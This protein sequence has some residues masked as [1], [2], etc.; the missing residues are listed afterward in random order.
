MDFVPA[1][2]CKD[3]CSFGDFDGTPTYEY[4]DP[5]EGEQRQWGTK[6]GF[7]GL[8]RAYRHTYKAIAIR[9]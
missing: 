5:R 3:G 8:K 2:F 7:Q 1:H 4:E 9:R 6:A